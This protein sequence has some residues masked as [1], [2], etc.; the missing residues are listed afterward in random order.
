VENGLIN[1]SKSTLSLNRFSNF[2]NWN[3]RTVTLLMVIIACLTVS[4]SVSN[5]TT[6]CVQSDYSSSVFYACHLPYL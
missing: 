1:V 3:C 4:L 2:D 5:G 6:M